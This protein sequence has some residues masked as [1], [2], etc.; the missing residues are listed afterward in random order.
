MS[1]CTQTDIEARVGEA[2][3]TRLADHDG[4]DSPDATVV[5]GALSAAEALMDSYLGVRFAVP[6]L[7]PDGEP[8]EVLRA[9]AVS[10]AV[11]FLRFGRDSVT[12]DARAQHAEDLAW[13][14][15]VAAGTVSLGVQPAPAESPGAPGVEHEGQQRL[16]G[17]SEPL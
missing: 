6:V 15:A 5:E 13:L 14:Q 2:E 4:D 8:P 11:Y 1:Y 16:F 3:L 12:E 9:R 10:L 7:K 17:R